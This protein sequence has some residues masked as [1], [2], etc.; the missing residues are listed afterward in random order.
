V[1]L[2]G[3]IFV[4]LAGLLP[5]CKSSS[6]AADLHGVLADSVGPNDRSVADHSGSGEQRPAG[7]RAVGRWPDAGLLRNAYDL[8]ACNGKGPGTEDCHLRL[9]VD[10]RQCSPSQPCSK[11]VIYWSGGEQSCVL[12]LYDA[13][14][15]KYAA[16]GFVAACAQPFTTSDE[17]GRYP[18]YQELE[19]MSELIAHLRAQPEVQ[20]GWDGTRLLISGVSHGASAP[21][22][23][24]ASKAALRAQ[25]ALWT[26][27]KSTALILYDGISNPAT[28]EEWAGAQAVGSGCAAYHSR[29]V[30]RYGD[31][32]PLIHSCS[33]NACYCGNPPH[34][35]EW[36][37]DTVVL[38]STVP[39]SPYSCT[40][41]TPVGA[42]LYRF[43][44][45][46]GSAAA[47][48]AALGDLIPSPQQKLA[49]DGIASCPGVS[50][51]YQ[52]YPSCGHAE[53]GSVLCG[54][55][56]SMAWLKTQGW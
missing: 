19:R 29:W 5:G 49:H 43:V 56:D 24:V 11:L 41:V 52:V 51:S 32:S 40:D 12:G 50:A 45:C 35:E 20:A 33:N 27:T 4:G 46:E 6:P 28:L 54:Q 17:A 38:G 1:R 10:P 39:K 37:K 55:A 31:G 9:V 25:P 18:Y 36:A 13:L 48:C 44:S 30:G 23:A 42:V 16:D 47:A 8:K 22:M 26:G 3:L 53:C 2:R 14:L 15:E 7:D 21:L 34:S